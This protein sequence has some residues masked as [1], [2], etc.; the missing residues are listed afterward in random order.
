LRQLGPQLSGQPGHTE[1]IV[2]WE[3]WSKTATT[4]EV[5]PGQV[6]EWTIPLPDEVLDRI[7][8]RLKAGA[9]AKAE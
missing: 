2:P 7:R 6:N 3:S 9:N 5:R 1:I 4:F 8:K